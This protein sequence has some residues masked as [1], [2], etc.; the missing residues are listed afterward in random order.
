MGLIR[1]RFASLVATAT[2]AISLILIGIFLVITANL[3]RLY[4]NLKSRVELEVFLDDSLEEGKIK[5]LGQKIKRFEGVKE[6]SFVSKDDAALEFKQLFEGPQDAYFDALGYNP[7]PASFRVKLIESY[8]NSTGADKVYEYLCSLERVS[9]EDVV[10][11]RE[12]LLTLEKYFNLAVAADL[13]IG[14]IVCLSAL[15]LVSNNIR[16][17]IL[18]KQKIIETMKLVGATRFFIKLPLLIQ[19][20]SQG[21]LG[22]VISALFLYGIVELVALEVPDYISV[23]WKLYVLLASLGVFLGF[24]GSFT[25]I[26]R[27]L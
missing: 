18:S 13:L 23:D 3:E 17:I 9:E 6:V 19:G 4:K 25:A 15:L 24:A 21:F 22:G 7:L 12:F 10:F 5:E 2:V 27:Y 26:R 8:R 20:V 14:A 1:A 16:L 11:R